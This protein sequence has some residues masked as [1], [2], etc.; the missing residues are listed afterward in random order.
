MRARRSL[1][2]IYL[3]DFASEWLSD[4]LARGTPL[5]RTGLPG[6]GLRSRPRARAEGRYDFRQGTLRQLGGARLQQSKV[7][8]FIGRFPPGKD[9]LLVE[10]R[11]PTQKHY[12]ASRRCAV[13]R[14]YSAMDRTTAH[15][16]P[17][18]VMIC[19]P[20]VLAS[21]I[22]SLSLDFACCTCQI[23]INAPTSSD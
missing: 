23:A 14:R 17:C 2:K 19:G 13:R 7:Y 4:S 15:S 9:S 8:H 21:S 12:W 6:R 20:L 5:V 11:R 3:E 10:D 22:N 1:K 16:S 18:L